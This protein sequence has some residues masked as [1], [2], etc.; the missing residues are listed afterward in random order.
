MAEDFPTQ[1]SLVFLRQIIYFCSLKTPFS[2]D[3]YKDLHKKS[4]RWVKLGL[5][6]GRVYVPPLPYDLIDLRNSIEAVV[7][8]KI[9]LNTLIKV[10]NE[11]NYWLS[12]YRVTNSA[13]IEPL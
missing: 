5:I 1:P 10:G 12:V 2:Y 6:K 9:F 7:A 13:Y 11:L 4:P 3:D 8:T